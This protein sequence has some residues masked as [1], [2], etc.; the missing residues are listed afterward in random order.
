[1]G[2]FD[3]GSADIKPDAE[4]AIARIAVILRDHRCLTRIE[5]HTDNIPIHTA[6]FASNWELSTAR[7]TGM[8]RG[9]VEKY[10]ITPSLLSAAGYAEF[11]PAASNDSDE[12]RQLNRRVD[13]IILK[14]DHGFGIAPSAATSPA[15]PNSHSP[16]STDTNNAKDSN[17]AE[18]G[19]P[20]PPALEA[21]R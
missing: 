21:Q 1:M 5:G 13:L 11:R 20:T 7:A 15:Q 12:G 17:S 18:A 3:S 10:G 16:P 8:V 4:A 6:Q 9:L 2:F 14:S 19:Q